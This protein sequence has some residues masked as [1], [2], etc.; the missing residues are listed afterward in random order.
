MPDEQIDL[1]SKIEKEHP[2]LYEELMS[3]RKWQSVQ[4]NV[5]RAI[6][7]QNLNNNFWNLINHLPQ[8]QVDGIVTNRV[9]RM[10]K[11]S[12]ENLLK[13]ILKEKQDDD[14][15]KKMVQMNRLAERTKVMERHNGRI[16]MASKFFRNVKSPFN[17]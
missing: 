12:C 17:D 1:A 13:G 6:S 5:Q 9:L 11:K 8:K 15:K 3:K 14:N 16:K 7:D 2:V 10:D 4:K